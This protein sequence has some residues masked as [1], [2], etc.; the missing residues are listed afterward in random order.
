MADVRANMAAVTTELFEMALTL[1]NILHGAFKQ[2]KKNPRGLTVKL[3]MRY[4]CLKT[5]VTFFGPRDVKNLA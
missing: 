1:T 4:W 2:S 3:A 5:I